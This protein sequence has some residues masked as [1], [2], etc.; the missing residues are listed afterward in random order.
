MFKAPFSFAGR[1]GRLEYLLSGLFSL[2]LYGMGIGIMEAVKEA[3]VSASLS[4]YR[5]PGSSW[6]KAGSAPMTPAGMALSA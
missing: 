5:R 4:S 6:P 3:A 2:M 1:I